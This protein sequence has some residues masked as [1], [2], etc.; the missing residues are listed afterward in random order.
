MGWCERLISFHKLTVN[1]LPDRST[2]LNE[3]DFT[4]TLAIDG[5]TENAA[6]DLVTTDATN[7][8]G[9]INIDNFNGDTISV[10][11]ETH[12]FLGD[13]AG[14]TVLDL[15]SGQ[16]ISSAGWFHNVGGVLVNGAP[17]TVFTNAGGHYSL[18]FGVENAV[19]GTTEVPEPATALLLGLGAIGGAIKRRKSV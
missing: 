3:T 6:G 4:F 13:L 8:I 11:D 7:G 12:M 2:V 16:C 14:L 10:N 5:V 18:G 19:T 17:C 1:T 15:I 9:S